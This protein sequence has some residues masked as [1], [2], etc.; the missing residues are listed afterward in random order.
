MLQV[1]RAL[2]VI[3][4]F[5]TITYIIIYLHCSNYWSFSTQ[6]IIIVDFHLT[7]REYNP[8]VGRKLSQMKHLNTLHIFVA[9]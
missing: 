9:C 3:A 2:Y 8:F 5:N 7:K 4:C 6:Y 1:P